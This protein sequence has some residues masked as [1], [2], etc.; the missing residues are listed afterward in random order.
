MDSAEGG[1]GVAGRGSEAERRMVFLT[2][3]VLAAVAF[4]GSSIHSL[5]E[6]CFGG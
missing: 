4:G 6:L 3:T 5:K 1:L 2:Q